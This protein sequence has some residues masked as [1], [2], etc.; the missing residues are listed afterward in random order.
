MN[1]LSVPDFDQNGT[2]LKTCKPLGQVEI[3]VHTACT[4]VREKTRVCRWKKVCY[5]MLTLGSGQGQHVQDHDAIFNV[6]VRIHKHI[7]HMSLLAF[8]C[9]MLHWMLRSRQTKGK[10]YT[11]TGSDFWQVYEVT[12]TFIVTV[13][14]A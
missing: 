10:T 8:I 13:F 1:D 7:T 11:L 3:S 4:P 2:V 9:Q 12:F 6:P 14:L 5:L